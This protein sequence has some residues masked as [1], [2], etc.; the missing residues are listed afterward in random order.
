MADAQDTTVTRIIVLRFE[1]RQANRARRAVLDE[2]SSLYEIVDEEMAITTAEQMGVDVSTPAGMAE[3]VRELGVTLV[4]TGR[5]SGRRRRARTTI[6]VVDPDGTELAQRD[7]PGPRRARRT[8]GRIG[9]L[10][11]EAIAEANQ[12]LEQQRAAAEAAANPPPPQPIVYDDEED[13]EDESPAQGWRHP[14]IQALVGLRVR[15]VGTYVDDESIFAQHFFEASFYPEIEIAARFRPWTD[16][17]DA[18]LRGIYFGLLGSFSVGLSYFDTMDIQRDMTSFRF[19]GDVGYGYT[20]ADVFEI[21]GMLGFG[22]EGVLLSDPDAFPS[23]LFSFLRAAVV[24]ALPGL[25]A[26]RDHRGRARRAHRPR[27]RGPRDGLRA[28][29]LLRRRRSLPRPRRDHRGLHLHGALRLPDPL[30]ELR[31][32]RRELRQRLGRHRRGDRDALPRRLQLLAGAQ[33]S[34]RSQARNAR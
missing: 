12:V 31:G 34:P 5:V 33:S 18:G 26:V 11:A 20:I 22:T 7:A 32:R 4:V 1:G 25:R 3:V 10:A 6:I 13:D 17:A 29:P 2:V 16:D 14:M 8:G 23:T 19:R 21:Q 27:R 30:A 24:G 28:E 15:N 9:Q